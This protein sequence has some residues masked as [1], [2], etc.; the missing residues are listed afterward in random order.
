MAYQA[1]LLFGVTFP[2]SLYLFVFS[3]SVCSYNFHWYLTPPQVKAFSVKQ[4][5]NLSNKHLHLI[6]AVAGLLSSAVAAFLLIEHW[7]WL[8]LTAFLTFMYSAPMIRHPLFAMLR[9]IAVGKTVYLAFAWTHVTALLP[10]LIEIDSLQPVHSWYV[11]NRFFFLYAICI[12]FDRR[13]RESDRRAGIKSL[14]T[15]LDEKGIEGVF[16]VSLLMSFVTGLLLLQWMAVSSVVALLVPSIVLAFLYKESKQSRSDYLY[17]F[18]L[19][20]LMALS[21]PILILL[22]FVRQIF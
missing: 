13:D 6:L 21:A 12:V 22:S 2:F 11:V 5:W 4:R 20:G 16:W 8:W 17:Y 15:V 14:V 10:L 18:L 7:L 19:D 9:K 1:S 3:G